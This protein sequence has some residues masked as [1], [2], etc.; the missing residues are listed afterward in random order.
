MKTSQLL[1]QPERD[2]TTALKDV[3]YD[4]CDEAA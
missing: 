3:A 4:T 1:A 2:L